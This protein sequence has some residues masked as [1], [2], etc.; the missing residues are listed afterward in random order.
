MSLEVLS[1]FQHPHA[2]T[3]PDH[4]YDHYAP[5]LTRR[6]RAI[7]R[8]PVVR[9]AEEAMTPASM[10]GLVVLFPAHVSR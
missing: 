7:E 4:C 10:D 2:D 5:R 3:G 9:D 8:G 6:G 1:D